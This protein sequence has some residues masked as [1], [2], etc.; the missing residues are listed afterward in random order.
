M[1]V[2]TSDFSGAAKTFDLSRT[3]TEKVNMEFKA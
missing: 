2:H 1:I 3:W